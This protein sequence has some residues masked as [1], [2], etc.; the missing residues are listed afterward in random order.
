MRDTLVDIVRKYG[1]EFEIAVEFTD[2]SATFVTDDGTIVLEESEDGIA[3]LRRVEP[4]DETDDDQIM[5]LSK[6]RRHFS[7]Y[8]RA[9]LEEANKE[10]PE[11]PKKKPGRPAKTEKTELP[12][13]KE[14][15]EPRRAPRGTKAA[16][17]AER[18]KKA[19]SNDPPDAPIEP[20]PPEEEELPDIRPE[21]DKTGKVLPECY[22]LMK[23]RG[24][25][26][27]LEVIE[28][29][30][31]HLVMSGEFGTVEVLANGTIISDVTGYIRILN[32]E[33][34]KQPSATV[35]ITKPPVA[36]PVKKVPVSRELKIE[37]ASRQM[38]FIKILI[39]AP[40]GAGKTLGALLL[41]Y[42]LEPDWSKIFIVDTEHRSG[43]L[44]VGRKVDKIKIG[45]YKTIVLDAP[46]S[47]KRYLEAIDLAEKAGAK[48]LI[49]DSLTHAWTAEGGLL[50]MHAAA[51]AASRTGNSYTAWKDITP[52]HA[53][54]I[55]KILACN[56][57]VI[58][59]TRAK[60]Q[61]ELVHGERGMTPKK[62]GMGPIFR[63]G[64][65]YEVSIALEVDADT[66]VARVTKDRTMVFE[67]SP[68]IKI[69]PEHGAMI[70]NWLNEV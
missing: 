66:H 24:K 50:D 15:T 49:L 21:C 10:E 61:Y 28:E 14:A 64:I 18:A 5:R 62:M 35:P 69:T 38:A 26:R 48:V 68:N 41:G 53:K 33:S 40:A 1:A 43:S 16:E 36:A 51:T 9:A 60:T 29:N 31:E 55:E 54:L 39:S 32:G 19:Q 12:V 13:E 37:D 45:Q 47:P 67:D 7:G 56:M 6:I 20:A 30:L 42:G 57:H 22:K 27:G 8:L 25:K 58:L 4:L 2:T 65:E 23:L 44:Y 59:T 34:A 70:K 17:D 11:P 52:L 3:N 46:Y 63:E